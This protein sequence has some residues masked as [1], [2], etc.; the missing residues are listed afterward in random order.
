MVRLVWGTARQV[1]FWPAASIYSPVASPCIGVGFIVFPTRADDVSLFGW[2]PFLRPGLNLSR[3]PCRTV[4][5][6]G[7]GPPRISA[8]RSVLEGGAARRHARA[9]GISP[10]MPSDGVVR[11]PVTRRPHVNSNLSWAVPL[12]RPVGLQA[13]IRWNQQAPDHDAPFAEPLGTWG[14]GTNLDGGH[15]GHSRTRHTHPPRWLQASVVPVSA[16]GR[17]A[18]LAKSALLVPVPSYMAST[19]PCQAEAVRAPGGTS[20]VST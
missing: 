7:H 9:G 3:T 16:W 8:A 2:E 11:G 10:A 19:A 1:L 13:R 20:P 17:L 18:D 6:D 5:K 15:R 4:V 12:V 14:V